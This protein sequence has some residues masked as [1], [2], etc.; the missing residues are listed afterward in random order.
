LVRSSPGE[1]DLDWF[2]SVNDRRNARSA[3]SSVCLSQKSWRL[4]T[5]LSHAYRSILCRRIGLV[6]AAAFNDKRR[7]VHYFEWQDASLRQAWEFPIGNRCLRDR[8]SH[9]VSGGHK[10]HSSAKCF[11]IVWQRQGASIV[12][13]AGPRYSG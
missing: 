4:R 12:A 10:M 9:C 5:A 3:D 6:A 13:D 2:D 11:V 1:L 7:S 8:L